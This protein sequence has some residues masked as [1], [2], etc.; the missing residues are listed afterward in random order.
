MGYVCDESVTAIVYRYMVNGSLY[1]KLHAVAC[2][3]LVWR[4]GHGRAK[5]T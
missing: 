3:E 2:V 4:G 5:R 1:D